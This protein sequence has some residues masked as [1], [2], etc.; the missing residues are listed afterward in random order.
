M[1]AASA[2]KLLEAFQ[3]LDSDGKKTLSKEFVSKLMTEEGEPFTQVYKF[4]NE[5]HW[6]EEK[7]TRFFFQQDELEEM[8]AAAV[9][10]QSGEIHYEYYINSLMVILVDILFSLVII[11]S[12]FHILCRSTFK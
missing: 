4:L 2:E 8:M 12:N 10:V 3:I 1:E 5:D 6:E 9:D 7:K 11:Y